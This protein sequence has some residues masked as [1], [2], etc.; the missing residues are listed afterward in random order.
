LDPGLLPG[1]SLLG[2]TGAN[3]VA[4]VGADL[5]EIEWH[6]S[7]REPAA[8]EAVRLVRLLRLDSDEPTVV[9]VGDAEV[10][11]TFLREARRST[12]T[13]FEERSAL[14][15]VCRYLQSREWMPPH[16]AADYGLRAK[17]IEPSKGVE[18]K[19]VA[20][21]RKP[22]EPL[23]PIEPSLLEVS[24]ETDVPKVLPESGLEDLEDLELPEEDTP[25]P[26]A[27]PVPPNPVPRPE[28]PLPLPQPEPA[29]GP[30]PEPEPGPGPEEPF[31][32]TS[33]RA[34]LEE[35]RRALEKERADAETY[36]RSRTQEIFS[37]EE[38]LFARERA[39]A[40]KEEVVEARARAAT[41]RLIDLEKDSARREV[42]RFLGAIPGMSAAQADV[43]ATAFPDI[44]SLS[45]ADEK[46]LTQCK[47]VTDALARAVRL[48]LAPGELE[49]ER[50]SSRLREEARAFTEE[51]DYDAALECYDRLLRAR[52]EEIG[53]WFDRAE[54]LVLLDRPEE[55]LQCYTRILDFDRGNR[56]ASYERANLLFGLGRLPAAVDALREALRL[57]PTKS[58]EVAQKA[59]Q[60]RRD[61]HPNEAVL[62][63]Q[64]ILEIAP[65]DPRAVLGLGDTFIDLGDSD[66]AEAQFTRALGRDPQNAPIL[67]RKGELLERKGRWGAAIQYYNRAIALRWNYPEPWLAKGE[68][69][70][71]HARAREALEC[72]EKVVSFDP[73]R[74]E[75][76][77]GEARA[78]AALGQREEAEAALANGARIAADH[79]AVLAARE[80]ITQMARAVPEVSEPLEPITDFPSLAKAFEAIE[81][82]VE[83]PAA[84]VPPDFQSFVESIE[85]EK[86][87]T[88][89]LLQLAELAIE[90]G[91][92]QMGLL[93]YE[94]A[95]E[96][97]PRNADA[98]TGKGVA[99]QQLERF[100][101]ALEAYDRA[102]ALKPSHELARKWRETC[103]R[104]VQ[105]EADG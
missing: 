99:L 10:L 93:R 25:L 20:A 15:A 4:I 67:F 74:I 6:R 68:I 33:Q 95:I 101:E 24:A 13:N 28:P 9:S 103:A 22:P 63:F 17:V 50:R 72:F 38:L 39:V 83:P 44:A 71:H 30:V 102:L 54:L 7:A 76:W 43:I 14:A 73:R 42:L 41:E 34:E 55:A 26:A 5:S 60:L 37:K 31:V 18:S 49:D 62:L 89:V 53:V 66:A 79:P 48:E 46:A 40:S 3:E 92:P 100:R 70:L 65:D 57:E 45:A 2:L 85:P 91:D 84:S 97:E 52:P 12:P 61:G 82:E 27:Q 56:Q 32:D 36:V 96:R 87:D 35:S 1:P 104:H 86:E 23:P 78:H 105:S 98:W 8:T 16:L 59:E 81:E 69:L 75:A 90:G 77:A 19:P 94:Q 80:T 29:P 64:A 58:R 88:H 51:G 11:H 21:P 47:G